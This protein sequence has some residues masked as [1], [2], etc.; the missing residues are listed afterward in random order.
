MHLYI[1]HACKV[2]KPKI[3]LNNSINITGSL[4][5]GYAKL[6]EVRRLMAL[7]RQSGKKLIAYCSTGAEKEFFFALGEIV[8]LNEVEHVSIPLV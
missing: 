3:Y 1:L 6:T 5:C 7:Y 4:N 8:Y 2:N